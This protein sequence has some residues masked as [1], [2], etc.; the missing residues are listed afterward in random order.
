MPVILAGGQPELYTGLK[1][2]DW[3]HVAQWVGCLSSMHEIWVPSL[4]THKLAVVMQSCHPNTW[5]AETEAESGIHG[6]PLP[7][8]VFIVRIDF[9]RPCQQTSEYKSEAG[10]VVHPGNHRTRKAEAGG[11]ANLKPDWD[12]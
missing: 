12:A 11:P 10:M 6:H 4:A 5:E 7:P 1:G 9:M 2:K 8:R 3:G